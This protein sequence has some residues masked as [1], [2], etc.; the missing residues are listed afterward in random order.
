[1]KNN[2]NV[3]CIAIIFLLS[4][5]PPF[6]NSEVSEYVGLFDSYKD[7]RDRYPNAKFEE[8]K[9]AWATPGSQLVKISGAGLSGVLVVYFDNFEYTLKNSLEN[10]EIN[11]S[12]YAILKEFNLALNNANNGVR[13]TWVRFV[14][15]NKIPLSMLKN[16]YGEPKIEVSKTDFSV[17]AFWA[18][19]VSATLDESNMVASVTYEPTKLD[20]VY[21]LEKK[22]LS[23]SI[24]NKNGKCK[25]LTKDRQKFEKEY[26]VRK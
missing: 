19:G 5:Y 24:G 17:N 22:C 1:M 12:Q 8:M 20:Y 4:I 15:H 9:A 25:S 23:D 10:G 2:V 16:V 14:P 3:V 21:F 18:R 11:Q 7:L 6:A 13:H 26:G